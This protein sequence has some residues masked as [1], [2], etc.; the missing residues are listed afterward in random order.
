[1]INKIQDGETMEYSNSGSAILSGDVVVIGERIGVAIVDIAATSGIGS[2]DVSGVFELAKTTSQA[3]SQGA[4]LFWAAGTSKL[5][6]TATANT[7]AG[8]AF[9][10]AASAATTGY[11]KL[12]AKPKQATVIAAIATV[13]GSDAATTQTLANATKASVNTIIAAL[14]AA[15]LMA[16]S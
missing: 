4:K 16:N 1:M 15:G 8:Y 12:E 6:T 5:T 10:A 9:E 11:C 3:W 2:V 14:K 7:P 13:D